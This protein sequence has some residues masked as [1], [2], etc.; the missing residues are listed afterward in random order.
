[1]A[2]GTPSAALGSKR[3]SLNTSSARGCFVGSVWAAARRRMLPSGSRISTPQTSARE[4][5]ANRATCRS[6]V[7]HSSERW[8][9]RLALCMNASQSWLRRGRVTSSNAR[10]ALYDSSSESMMGAQLPATLRS[11]PSREA[12]TV[13][14]GR[15]TIS[16]P[17]RV[18]GTGLSRGSRV[19][20]SWMRKTSSTGC[21]SASPSVHAV[22][23]SASAFMSVTCPAA[24]V[25][26]TPSPMPRS[27]ASSRWRSRSMPR[28]NFVR[29]MATAIALPTDVSMPRSY[30]VSPS[31]PLYPSSPL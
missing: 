22:S 11:V 13:S 6:V 9:K 18:L 8:S 28:T 25:V 1:M 29:S 31:S 27:V 16:C 20:A 2:F 19:F 14:S 24:S 15:R 23:R 26:H 17:P 10:T 4:A 7:S 5:T 21:P 30:T 12:S 3:A